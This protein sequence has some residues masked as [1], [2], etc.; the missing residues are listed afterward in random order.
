MWSTIWRTFLAKYVRDLEKHDRRFGETR[1]AKYV[2]DLEKRDRRF[3]ETR[4][5][6]YVGDLEKHG[7]RSY[8]DF[9]LEFVMEYPRAW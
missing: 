6:K 8:G 4:S 9:V 5:M 2:G 7:R 3:G 1:S